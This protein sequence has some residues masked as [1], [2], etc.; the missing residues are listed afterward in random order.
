M[1]MERALPR[2]GNGRLRIFCRS[3]LKYNIN[4]NF[5]C[6][7]EAARCYFGNKVVENKDYEFIPM[8]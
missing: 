5:T 3:R 4:H 1:H 2:T 7:I 8:Q 6:G